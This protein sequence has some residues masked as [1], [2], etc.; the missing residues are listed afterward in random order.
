MKD[1]EIRLARLEV[2]AERIRDPELPLEEA[3]AVFEEGIGL[4]RTLRRDL[5]TLQ[6]KVEMLLGGFGEDGES[7]PVVGEFDRG[8]RSD[9]VQ[10]E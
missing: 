5:E 3:V 1:F 6:G 4:S 8:A 9:P 2:L 7:A 10:D